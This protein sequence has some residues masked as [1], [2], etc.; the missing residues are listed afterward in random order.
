VDYEVKPEPPDEAR[1]AIAAALREL[2]RD[3]QHPAYASGWRRAGIADN[4]GLP[5]D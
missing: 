3:E 4:L 2:L 5:E 1:E